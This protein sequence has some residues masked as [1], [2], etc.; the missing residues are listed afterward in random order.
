[1]KKRFWIDSERFSSLCK[2]VSLCVYEEG[3]QSLRGEKCV[4]VCA[5]E[6]YYAPTIST[7][8]LLRH[9]L[10]KQCVRGELEE[11]EEE[12]V[13]GRSTMLPSSSSLP[14]LLHACCISGV[15]GV[16]PANKEEE[17]RLTT[18]L[19]TTHPKL[20]NRDIEHNLEVSDTPR[21]LYLF[22]GNPA[23]TSTKKSTKY[24]FTVK[25]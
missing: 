25:T 7:F 20:L 14:Y 15:C 22:H 6:E 5:L 1:M 17:K 4:C 13:C 10:H 11:E 3:E 24:S 16:L 9:L 2:P 12:C 23:S 18:W 19:A 8:P 21:S